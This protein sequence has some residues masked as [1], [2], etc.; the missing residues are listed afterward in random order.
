VEGMDMVEYTTSE[1][2]VD[3]FEREHEDVVLVKH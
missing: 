3:A 2:D 1:V